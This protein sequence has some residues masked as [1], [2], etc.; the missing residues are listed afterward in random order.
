M[1]PKKRC[2][3]RR[4]AASPGCPSKA[5]RDWDEPFRTSYAEY[6]VNQQAKDA[7]VHAVREAVGG[8][9]DRQRLDP[10]WLERPQAA[11]RDPAARRVRGGHRQPARGALRPRQRVAHH[12]DARRARRAPPHADPAAHDARAGVGRIRSSTGR[13]SSSTPN[14]WVA[15]AARH[16]VDELLLVLEPDRVRGRRPT[17]C[18][19]P[20]SPTCSSSASR[21]WRTSAGDRDVREDAAEHPD[22]R[23]APRPDRAAVLEILVAARPR[24]RAVPA[25]QVVLAQLAASSRS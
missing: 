19:R 15:I 8:Y 5:W 7:S 13:T 3:Q 20:A 2:F 11:R 25:R 14:N 1:S 4:S 22:R 18:S 24:I 21:R 17:S 6:V 10:A 16:L 23:G 9:D 12:G